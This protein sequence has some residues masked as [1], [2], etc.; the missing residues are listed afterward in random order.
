MN[1]SHFKNVLLI[2]RTK[3]H[4]AYGFVKTREGIK[5]VLFGKKRIR[6]AREIFNI[7]LMKNA[8]FEKLDDQ[9][10]AVLSLYLCEEKYLN[11]ELLEEELRRFL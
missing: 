10:F 8:D 11:T 2:E 6:R 5:C 9:F 7:M 3:K 4:G 1:V